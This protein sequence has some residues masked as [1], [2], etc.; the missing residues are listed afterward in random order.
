MDLKGSKRQE[1]DAA[2]VHNPYLTTLMAHPENASLSRVNH[3]HSCI[4]P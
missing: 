3:F 4:L 2:E 1:Y